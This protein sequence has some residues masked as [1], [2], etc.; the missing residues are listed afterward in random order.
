M[1]DGG[2]AKIREQHFLTTTHKHIFRLDITVDE[3]LLVSVLQGVG[4]LLDHRDDHWE[5][6]QAAFGIPLS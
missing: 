3:F 4:Y 5:R 2:N 1:S 6:D